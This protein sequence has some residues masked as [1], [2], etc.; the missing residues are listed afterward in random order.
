MSITIDAIA[1]ADVR[2]G[3]PDLVQCSASVACLASSAV[4]WTAWPPYD[5]SSPAPATVLQLAR[6]AVLAIRNRAMSLIMLFSF[7]RLL[8]SVAGCESDIFLSE[9]E[10]QEQAD[11]W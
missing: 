8:L 1:V 3:A 4:L 9:L 11:P 2:D 7:E 5:M 10:W 6:R